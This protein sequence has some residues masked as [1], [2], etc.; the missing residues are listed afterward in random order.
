MT[1]A[2]T[3][4]IVAI[5]TA[6]GA[7]GVG[8]VRLSGPRSRA[9][10]EVLCGCALVPRYAHYVKL[11]AGEETIDDGIALYFAAPASFTGEHVVEL[12]AHG[13]PVVLRRI[14]AECNARG[15]RNARPGEFSER[16][17][18]NGKIDLAQAEAVA[19]L[20]AAGDTRAAR[21]ARRRRR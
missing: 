21:A 19:D 15:A 2:D 8:V 10:A 6:P 1:T 3:D 11:R 5:A 20:I 4:T 12:Q 9:I 7:G 13:S 16:A 14:V 17:Y 18:L